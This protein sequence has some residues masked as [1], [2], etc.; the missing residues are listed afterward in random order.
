MFFSLYRNR[1]QRWHWWMDAFAPKCCVIQEKKERKEPA[2]K[3]IPLVDKTMATSNV[4]DEVLAIEHATT[5]RFVVYDNKTGKRKSTTKCIFFSSLQE[6]FR[7]VFRLLRMRQ[8]PLNPPRRWWWMCSAGWKRF[9]KNVVR[10]LLLRALARLSVWSFVTQ[11]RIARLPHWIKREKYPKKRDGD[12]WGS[13]RKRNG[14]RDE[15]KK[16]EKKKKKKRTSKMKKR[17]IV[18]E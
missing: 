17:R 12:E 1:V 2:A 4:R 14:V 6:K 5:Q 11:K 13:R 10:A 7:R 9:C 18:M 15:K 3:G 16:R 8:N